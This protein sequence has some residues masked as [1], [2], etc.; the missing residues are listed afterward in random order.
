MELEALGSLPS[1]FE[2]VVTAARAEFGEDATEVARLETAAARAERIVREYGGWLREQLG[3]AEYDFALGSALYDELIDLRA[4]DGLTTDEILEIGEQQLAENRAARESL[5]R[6][7]ARR[8]RGGSGRS[9]QVGPSAR[10]RTALTRYRA[11]M[12]ESV[13]RG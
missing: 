13:R 5:A 11:A 3:R 8:D 1:L 7:I 10:L 12:D 4:F 9:D 6:E 2:E